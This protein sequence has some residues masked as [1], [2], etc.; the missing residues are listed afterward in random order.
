MAGYD[1]PACK[2]AGW[3]RDRTFGSAGGGWILGHKLIL[4]VMRAQG[5]GAGARS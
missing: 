2:K 1:V 3:F 4:R 5:R